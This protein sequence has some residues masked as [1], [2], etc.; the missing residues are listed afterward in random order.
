MIHVNSDIANDMKT[1]ESYR[2]RCK[3]ES[4]ETAEHLRGSNLNTA[5]FFFIFRSEC[6]KDRHEMLRNDK[7]N[8]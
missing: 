3:V 4:V 7:S 1:V 6:V 8:I 2:L 5:D